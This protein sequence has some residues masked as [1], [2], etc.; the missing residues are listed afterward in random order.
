MP[1]KYRILASNEVV[2]ENI[3]TMDMAHAFAECYSYMKYKNA[4]YGL[5]KV[6]IEQY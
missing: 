1:A 5:F 4:I 3:S 2:A 6:R